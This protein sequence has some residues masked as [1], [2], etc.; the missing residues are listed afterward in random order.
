MRSK[1]SSCFGLF[2]A[3]LISI[4]HRFGSVELLA[5]SSYSSMHSQ[6]MDAHMRRYYVS[7]DDESVSRYAC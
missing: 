6:D 5:Q 3:D 1:K 2:C 4:V 7:V